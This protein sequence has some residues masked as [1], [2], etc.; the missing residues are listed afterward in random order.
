MDQSITLTIDGRKYP[1][2]VSSPEM[3]EVL[4]SAAEDIKAMLNRY[5][6][7][8]PDKTLEDK[9]VFVTLQGTVQKIS[10]QRK[11]QALSDEVSTFSSDMASY[12]K[13]IEK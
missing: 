5:T 1:L 8:F 13:G 3:E 4:R 10:A 2:K 6:E 11:L 9:L 7:K 12:L